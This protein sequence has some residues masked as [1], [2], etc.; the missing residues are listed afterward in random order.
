MDETLFWGQMIALSEKKDHTLSLF[1]EN[2]L[3]RYEWHQWETC[4]N[5]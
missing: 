5:Q 2:M 4:E 1:T 3:A